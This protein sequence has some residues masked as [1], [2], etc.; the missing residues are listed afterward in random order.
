MVEQPRLGII[1]GT[2]LTNFNGLED[3]R[4]IEIDTPYGKPSSPVYL[5]TLSGA[6]VAF[7][8]RHGAGHTIMPTEVNNRA[9]IFAL[10]SIGVRRLLSISA[11]GS[12]RE[13]YAPGHVVLPDQVVDFTRERARTFFGNGMV[14]HIS[15]AE[16][17]CPELT[18]LVYDS[19]AQT[20]AAVH[21]GGTAITIEG[22]RFSTKA[23][24]HLFR[25]WGM[26]V[27]GMTT[28][29]EIFLARE[30]QMCYVAIAHVTDF[31]VWHTAEESVNVEMI[32]QILNR[33]ITTIQESIQIVA[34]NLPGKSSC[35]CSHSLEK[36]VVTD[37]ARIPAVTSNSLAWL[38]E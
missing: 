20:G 16:P 1:G 34:Q 8:A 12:L 19:V 26:S 7:L 28:C 4:V 13:D 2:G 17:F 21:K 5:G 6:R 10:K 24:S 9:N 18:E 11:C 22:P 35:D 36:A 3:L 30:A 23:E 14:A 25:S 37:P 38:S 15:T 27:I 31:D 32:V 33:N 29:P